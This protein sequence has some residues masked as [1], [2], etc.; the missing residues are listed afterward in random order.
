MN[1]PYTYSAPA[2]SYVDCLQEGYH[3]WNLPLEHL[4]EALYY[5][6]R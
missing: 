2:P 5:D 3:D 4:D 6:G 1:P